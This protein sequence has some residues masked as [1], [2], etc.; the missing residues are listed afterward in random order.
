MK[1]A[2]VL[3]DCA[4]VSL[5]AMPRRGWVVIDQKGTSTMVLARSGAGGQV[6][7]HGM[8]LDGD[9]AHIHD[10]R[11]ASNQD[12]VFAVVTAP[13]CSVRPA[14][15]GTDPHWVFEYDLWAL[16]LAVNPAMAHAA[17]LRRRRNDYLL[18]AGLYQFMAGL[19][20]ISL[21]SVYWSWQQR[22]HDTVRALRM[23]GR[24]SEGLVSPMLG[25]ELTRWRRNKNEGLAGLVRE[26][27]ESVLSPE[28]AGRG[29]HA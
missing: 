12:N 5:G 28:G 9:R 17:D 11:P 19:G 26:L 8:F 2:N 20:W 25:A 27:V 10:A 15:T 1:A 23:P 21:Y 7:R 16:L 18:P 14:A 4:S 6:L 3:V 22:H 24:N 29:D 13:A